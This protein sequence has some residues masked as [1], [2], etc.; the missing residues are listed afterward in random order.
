MARCNVLAT[1]LALWIVGVLGQQKHQHSHQHRHHARQT[2]KS[3]VLVVMT[4][5]QGKLILTRCELW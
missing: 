5:D 3:N 2:A 4:D 1:L